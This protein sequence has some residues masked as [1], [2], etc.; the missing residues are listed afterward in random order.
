MWQYLT[1]V[2]SP[3]KCIQPQDVSSVWELKAYKSGTQYTDMQISLWHETCLFGWTHKLQMLFG[4]F[5][6]SRPFQKAAGLFLF[7]EYCGS[8]E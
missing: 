1:L 5:P 4:V 8:L 2:I 7:P 6:D 3:L